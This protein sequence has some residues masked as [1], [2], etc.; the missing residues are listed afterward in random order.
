[1]PSPRYTA[2]PLRTGRELADRAEKEFQKR[3]DRFRRTITWLSFLACLGAVGWLVAAGSRD[4]RT[5]YEA[6]PV[7]PAHRFFENDCSECHTT[8]APIDR[9]TLAT[10]ESPRVS[11]VSND[12]CQKC[13][14]G[15]PHYQGQDSSHDG[16]GC[17]ACHREHRHD[18]T[19]L[20]GAN[21]QCIDCHRDLSKYLAKIDKTQTAPQQAAGAVDGQSQR[22]EPPAV[23]I[24]S[25]SKDHPDFD[26]LTVADDTPL[27]FNHKKHLHAKYENGKLVEGLLNNK[28]EL[29]DLSK[30]C[31]VC[32]QPDSQK[33]YMAPIRYQDHCRQ[34]HELYFDNE[35]F[36]GEAVPHGVDAATLRGFLTEK[37]MALAQQNKLKA[38]PPEPV[39]PLPGRLRHEPSLTSETL[40]SVSNEAAD[41]DRRLMAPIAASQD[42]AREAALRQELVLFGRDALGGC[43]LCHAVDKA[44]AD[45]QQ[46][47]VPTS[48]DAAAKVDAGF[49]PDWVIKSPKI[50]DRWM[51]HSRF[52]HDS[53]RFLQCVECHQS[54][55]RQPP[56]P[57]TQ[58]ELTSDVLMPSIQ[59]CQ[60]CH[61]DRAH[62]TLPDG[63]AATGP[64]I[65]SRCIDCHDYH[66]RES[67]PMNGSLL[68]DLSEERPLRK[69]GS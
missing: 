1:M 28:G 44:P 36:Q 13:H 18:V 47:G 3:P 67:E 39:R 5:I 55:K 17:A 24:T 27:R 25:F 11:S 48:N 66:D 19:L 22:S 68:L 61:A 57:V 38:A 9:L 14:A 63:T 46:T 16:L 58:S 62:V 23:T 65:A 34:C 10:S 59:V 32:H 64:G 53:H 49:E 51:P 7:A 15:S 52:S 30:D 12:K 31:G 6:G 4:G 33:L 29:V 69:D 35:N 42:A 50:P 26:A 54:F 56:V 43:R 45:D 41:A 20:A 21:P 2:A 8:W 60:S 40:Q 37:Y